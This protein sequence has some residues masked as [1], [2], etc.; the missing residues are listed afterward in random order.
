M[1]DRTHDGRPFRILHIIDEYTRACLASSVAR[2]IRSQDVILVL[3]DLFVRHGRP[4][5]I[6]S[7]NGPEFLARNLKTWLKNVLGVEPL[8]IEPGSPWENGYC[9]SFNG[10]MRDQL[11]N[12]E[13]FYTL[14]EAQIIIERWRTYYN[15]VRPHSSLGGQPPVPEAVQH[16]AEDSHGRWYKNSR[17]VRLT[18]SDCKQNLQNDL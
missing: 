17:L 16:G 6:R 13:L 18:T 3:A 12:G 1:A 15:T 5:H 10:K 8:Y 11:L 7:D 2:R 4:A 9:E 14:K